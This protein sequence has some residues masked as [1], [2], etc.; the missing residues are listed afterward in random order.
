MHTARVLRSCSYALVALKHATCNKLTQAQLGILFLWSST[1]TSSLLLC[2][3]TT[4]LDS[5]ILTSIL[6]YQQ[7]SSYTILPACP[8]FRVADMAFASL[9]RQISRALPLRNV[10]ST[11]ASDSAN[12]TDTA[13]VDKQLQGHRRSSPK[14][15]IYLH[16]PTHSGITLHDPAHVPIDLSADVSVQV[17]TV[18]DSVITI[19]TQREG[20]EIEQ[21]AAKRRKKGF[22]LRRV[23]TAPP[24][25]HVTPVHGS[26]TTIE[27]VPKSNRV[28][29]WSYPIANWRKFSLVRRMRRGSDLKEARK[30]ARRGK[31]SCE[32]NS[33]SQFSADVDGFQNTG[34]DPY[35]LM[36]GAYQGSPSHMD[37]ARDELGVS[38]RASVDLGSTHPDFT[39]PTGSPTKPFTDSD[40][41]HGDQAKRKDSHFHGVMQTREQTSAD[42]EENTR[43]LTSDERPRKSSV[44]LLRPIEWI[45]QHHASISVR[46]SADSSSSSDS[47]SSSPIIQ[48]ARPARRIQEMIDV[49]I[50]PAIGSL[51]KASTQDETCMESGLD[52]PPGFEIPAQGQAGPAD[53]LHRGW[54]EYYRRSAESSRRTCHALAAARCLPARGEELQRYHV[55]PTFQEGP[56][57]IQA[58]RV[59]SVP[60]SSEYVSKAWDVATDRKGKGRRYVEHVGTEDGRGRVETRDMSGAAEPRRERRKSS[61]GACVTTVT[62]GECNF[63]KELG[64]SVT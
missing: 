21:T 17:M 47:P 30:E 33:E 5:D 45:R 7:Q 52:L 23:K 1:Q 24:V 61:N 43:A 29:A 22:G 9:K 18:G 31:A 26:I 8:H 58:Q 6:A 60:Y 44:F 32:L 59:Q 16:S 36:S 2:L 50:Q 4:C 51:P 40:S 57:H 11:S 41:L 38:P 39:R 20:E 35:P 10:A 3:Q 53:W 62:L 63:A 14:A 19:E 64:Q 54:E 37:F 42:I 15:S 28:R 27:S 13:Q 46:S 48:P 56:Q 12:P 34:H 25:T 55:V 49:Q